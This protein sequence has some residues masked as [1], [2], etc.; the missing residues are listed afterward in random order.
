MAERSGFLRSSAL[1]SAGVLLSRLTGLAR[2]LLLIAV[3]GN[4]ALADVYTFANNVPNLFYELLA[5]GVLSAVLLPLFVDLV[6]R[7]DHEATSAVVSV[8][9]GALAAITADGGVH[10]ISYIFGWKAQASISKGGWRSGP[11][12]SLQIRLTGWLGC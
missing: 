3:L 8:A 7:D 5:G 1:I 4:S 10:G 9:V 12:Q 6:R 11:I 2:T